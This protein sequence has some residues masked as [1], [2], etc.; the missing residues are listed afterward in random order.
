MDAIERLNEFLQRGTYAE[1]AQFI[2]EMD[3]DVRGR[4]RVAL[5]CARFRAR[6]GYIND[7]LALLDAASTSQA[8]DELAALIALE[9]TSVAILRDG[10]LMQ[11]AREA[12]EFLSVVR[13][14]TSQSADVFEAISV[15]A[16]TAQIAF[17]YYEIDGQAAAAAR[18]S[19]LQA[20]DALEQVGRVLESLSAR[21]NHADWPR[22]PPIRA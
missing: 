2:E 4:P 11:A 21:H 5:E 16:R 14:S 15:A 18:G 12:E 7:A 20:A 13:Q 3:R 10:N 1:G 22:D 19:L 8:N 17:V 9:H 6:Q